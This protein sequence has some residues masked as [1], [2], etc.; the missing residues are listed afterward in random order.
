MTMGQSSAAARPPWYVRW[1]RH[2]TTVLLA[3]LLG[4]GVPVLVA[5]PSGNSRDAWTLVG[6]VLLIGAGSVALLG[7][8]LRLAGFDADAT[9]IAQGLAARDDQ[10]RLLERWLVRARWARF[11]G[12]TSGVIVFVL[13]TNGRGDVLLLGSGGIAIG[14]ALAEVHHV[15]RHRGPRTARLDVRTVGDY[16][17]ATDARWMIAVA[18]AGAA[19]AVAGAVHASTRGACWWGGAALVVIVL[20]RL[21]QQ[22]V[23]D[24][25]RPAIPESLVH[26]DDLAR[27]LAIGRGL[28]RPATYVGLAMVAHGCRALQP[29]LHG[30]ASLAATIATI[31]AFVRWWQNRRLG[32][33]FVIDTPRPPVVA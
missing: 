2:R 1:S 29:E 4:V 25:P 24:R 22:R 11:V 17:L 28:A 18:A 20:A 32:L 23:A 9:A 10:R 19:T 8:G 16:L 12:G 15:R 13:G 21:I 6:I 7:V 14:A 3:V 30:M 33:D 31:F 26:A 27:E 5:V